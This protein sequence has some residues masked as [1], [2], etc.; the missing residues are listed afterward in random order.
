MSREHDHPSSSHP[1][2]TPAAA[3]QPTEPSSPVLC[4]HCKRTADNGIRCQGICVADS[5]Y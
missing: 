5:E 2:A 4:P 1:T 3:E